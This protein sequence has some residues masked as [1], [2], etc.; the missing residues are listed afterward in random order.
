METVDTADIDRYLAEDLGNGDLTAA[1]VPE[2]EWAE[3]SVITR[4]AMVLCGSD[5]FDAVFQRLDCHDTIAW[6]YE[7]GDYVEAGSYLCELEGPA[8]SLL[9]GERTALNLLQTLSAT[10]TLARRYAEA[11]KGTGC[12]VLDTRK[13]L[14]GLRRAQKYAVRCGGCANHRMGLDDG[15]LIKENHIAAAGSITAAVKAA[16]ALNAGVTIE[17][18]VERLDQLEEALAAGTGRILLDNFSLDAMRQAVALNAGRAKLEVSGNVDLD[19][20]RAIAETG[21]DYISVGALTKHV[22]AVDLSMRITLVK[23]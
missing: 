9:T 17:V 21:V 5:W 22:R 1:I 4:E 12:T 13:T 7:D 11:V 15:I 2:A 14:P 19:N 6:R 20:I 16:E 23:E 10:A 8:R 3:A 18:E